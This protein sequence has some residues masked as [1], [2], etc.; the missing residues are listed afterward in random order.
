[1]KQR[2]GWGSAALYTQRN[3]CHECSYPGARRGGGVCVRRPTPADLLPLPEVTR[4]LCVVWK[5]RDLWM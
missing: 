5:G 3:A 1:M 4:P 2:C